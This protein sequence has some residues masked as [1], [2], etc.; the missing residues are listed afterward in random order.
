MIIDVFLL[1]LNKL[2]DFMIWAVRT[3]LNM[4]GTIAAI[5]ISG[6]DKIIETVIGD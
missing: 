6:I 3:A 2:A 4:C 5:V 1:V